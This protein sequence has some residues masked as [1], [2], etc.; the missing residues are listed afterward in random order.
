MLAYTQGVGNSPQGQQADVSDVIT[1][2]VQAVQQNRMTTAQVA[3]VE[4]DTENK[5]AQADLIAGQAAQAW[6]S[7]H[8]GYA[9][10]GLINKQADKIVEEIKNIPLEGERLKRAAEL[11]YQQANS[12]FQG[13]LNAV[14]QRSVIQATARKVIA[15]TGLI[16]LDID[17]AK[18][19][20]N[21]GNEAKQ[22]RP[23]IEM[24]KGL[25]HI[26]NSK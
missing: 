3:N 15:E 25:I 26:R 13:Q 14:E 2:A 16:N 22:L 1:P 20:D 4:A 24:I 11:L 7:A 19:F 12:E 18:A 10:V 5:K 6:S 21:L 23:V 17:A 8:Q 9:N